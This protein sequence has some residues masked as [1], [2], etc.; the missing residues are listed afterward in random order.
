MKAKSDASKNKKPVKSLIKALRVLDTL[1]DS[2]GGL[3]ITELSDLLKVPKST[4]H[5]LLSTMEDAGYVV[6]DPV[7]R[8]KRRRNNV[9]GAKLSVGGGFGERQGKKKVFGDGPEAVN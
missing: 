7:P 3:G 4:V 6:F 9:T 5:R 8:Q 2:V 1:A